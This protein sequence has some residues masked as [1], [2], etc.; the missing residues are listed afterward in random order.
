LLANLAQLAVAQ[1]LKPAV[2]KIVSA[3]AKP[4]GG[5]FAT[6]QLEML[7][8]FV[9]GFDPK[10][11]ARQSTEPKAQA[12]EPLTPIFTYTRKVSQN[13]DAAEAD[14]LASIQVLG[15]GPLGSD[16]DVRLL[17]ALLKPAQPAGLQKA[18]LDTLK[19]LDR[20][21]VASA[22]LVGWN[23]LSP[24]V[25]ADVL[26][27]LLSRDAWADQLLRSLEE[28]QIVAGEISPA[29]QQ[30]LLKQRGDSVRARATK[31]FAARHT[32]REQVV[33][34][35]E[36][37]KELVPNPG[38]GGFLYRQNCATCH[39][40]KGE[41]NEVGPDLGTVADKP[42]GTFLVAMLDPNQALESKYV[43]YTASTRD[44]REI[45]GIIASET[46]SSI[47]IRSSGGAEEVIARSEIQT[48]AS[49]KLSLMPEGLENVLPPQDMAD[50]I[51][52]IRSR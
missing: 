16:Q 38:R 9:N 11:P 3:L 4:V 12:L 31:I 15:R 23:E 20:P 37:I 5:T 42:I 8:G 24:S 32:D 49:S 10:T 35:Y 48:L 27:I 22:L 46:P 26:N 30:I 14:R 34:N 1:N 21:Q 43:S 36:S 45:T 52:F 2:T 17:G 18:A 29:H 28:G 25:R 13:P 40:L 51:A 19:R 39:R 33:R 44:G 6:W 50:L 7:N 47:T 41:G